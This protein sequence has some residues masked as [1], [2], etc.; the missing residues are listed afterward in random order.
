MSIVRSLLGII[1]VV[2]LSLLLSSDRRKA[3]W[4]SVLILLVV[5]FILAY[6]GLHT[7]VGVTVL[8]AVS[9]FFSWLTKQANG[10]IEFVFGE[11]STKAGI[12]FMN[13]LMPITFISALI[14]ILQYFNILPRVAKGI[15]WLVNKI[16]GMGEAE[17]YMAVATAILG[18]TNAF[19]TI[20]KQIEEFSNQQMTLFGILG[21]SSV[22]ATTLA[23]YMSMVDG[24]YVVVAVMLNMFGSFLVSCLLNPYDPNECQVSLGVQDDGKE[25]ENFFSVLSDYIS[26]GFNMALG[27]AGSLVGFMALITFLNSSCEAIFG[28]TFTEILGY[29]F[30]PLAYL[31]G[32]P[33]GDIVNAGSVMATK[34]IGN[35]F[36]ALGELSAVKDT[37]T[38]KSVAMLSS[39]CISFSNLGTLGMI[40]GTVK[41]M[42]EKQSK[43][44]SSNTVKITLASVLV[45]MLTASVVGAFY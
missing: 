30:S 4:K 35:E 25:K 16:T 21:M 40:I 39:Y 10:G 19:I 2:A 42:S 31:M 18:Q 32:I 44:I 23:S 20:E 24:K 41:G 5:M 8:D 17:S 22:S 27:I 15:G 6:V 38:A 33:S 37:L 7:T 36:V 12:F 26:N 34:L 14:G 1:T 9:G 43:V 29:V 45:S 13:V 11:E 28:M 3:R